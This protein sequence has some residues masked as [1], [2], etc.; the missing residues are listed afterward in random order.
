MT[1]E[2]AFPHVLVEG[3]PRTWLIDSLAL[4]LETGVEAEQRNSMN[5]VIVAVSETL[6][7]GS[8]RDRGWALHVPLSALPSVSPEAKALGSE[9]MHCFFAD[10]GF[11]TIA[12]DWE[13]WKCCSDHRI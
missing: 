8:Y 12:P 6:T 9:E 10:L 5:L 1:D 4:R 11:S 7:G 3:S 13:P 2:G